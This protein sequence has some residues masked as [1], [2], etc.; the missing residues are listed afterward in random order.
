MTDT[1]STEFSRVCLACGRRVPRTVAVCRCGA[2]IAEPAERSATA[3]PS[4]H[5]ETPGTAFASGVWTTLGVV[6]ALAAIVVITYSLNR[7]PPGPSEAQPVAAPAPPTEPPPALDAEIALATPPTLTPVAT[8]PPI[9]PAPPTT[10]DAAPAVPSL[11]DVVG[12]VM[13]AV[14]LVE[15]PTG[16][17]SAFFVAPDTLLTNVHVVG[18][19]SSVTIR[20]MS[21]ETAPARVQSLA[22]QFDVA[23]LKVFTP[24]SGQPVIPLG[25]GVNVRVGQEVIAIGSALG[26][27]QN[28]VTR[29]IVSAVR[30]TG[31]ATLV[32]TD[33]AVNPGNSGGPLLARDGTAIGIT[34]MGYTERQGLN[35][36]V[37]IEHARSVLEGRTEPPTS[38]AAPGIDL[39]ALSP[40]VPSETDQVREQGGQFYEQA[41]SEL[42]GRAQ[43]LDSDWQRFREG[44]YTGAV[45]G[46]FDREWFALLSERALPGVVAPSCGTF[47]GDF[48]R[49]AGEFRGLMLAADEAARRAGV[50]PGARRDARRKHRL[51]HPAWDR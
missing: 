11:E 24:A 19:N 15:T 49:T 12:R 51:S 44:C 9:A 38:A 46:A 2:P 32:Q 13:P 27:L 10:L 35:F 17:G 39:R 16:R 28:T 42:A 3:A 1:P 23:V 5:G 34:T 6:T 14:V 20:R 45:V 40:A 50:Y 33:A 43:R 29:G 41:L 25:S 30:Q 26:T 48:K 36:A 37:A 8:P 47:H 7:P 22:P 31:N 21:G 4:A 18:T